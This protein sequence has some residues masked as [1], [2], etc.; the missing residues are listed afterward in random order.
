MV[1]NKLLLRSRRFLHA[2]TAD[3]NSEPASVKR[4]VLSVR[5]TD[6]KVGTA[7]TLLLSLYLLLTMTTVGMVRWCTIQGWHAASY[8]RY[9]RSLPCYPTQPYPLAAFFLSSCHVLSEYQDPSPPCQF[10]LPALAR[11]KHAGAE[12]MHDPCPLGR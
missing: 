3:R 9:M 7:L 11:V 4:F 8:C 10:A 1:A 5:L 6:Y 12:T 2:N